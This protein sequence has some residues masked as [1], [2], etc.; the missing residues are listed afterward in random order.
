MRKYKLLDG[1]K[2]SQKIEGGGKVSLLI[3]KANSDLEPV[4]VGHL[5]DGQYLID[6]EVKAKLV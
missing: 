1:Y 2:L 3:E 5:V 6:D 4:V